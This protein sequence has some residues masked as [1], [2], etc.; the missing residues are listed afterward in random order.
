MIPIKIIYPVYLELKIYDLA[1]MKEEN[2]ERRACAKLAD[3][4]YKEIFYTYRVSA[5][6]TDYGKVSMIPVFD[7][8]IVGE[9]NLSF[10]EAV[11]EASNE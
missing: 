7:V 10:E 6:K 4:G 1:L 8:D 3:E 5:P 9:N 11:F 2:G